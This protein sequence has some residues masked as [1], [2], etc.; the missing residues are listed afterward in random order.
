VRNA[1][2]RCRRQFNALGCCPNVFF[3][4]KGKHRVSASRCEIAKALPR[5]V[6]QKR[7]RTKMA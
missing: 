3:D 2:G 4:R 6:G 1:M 7:P 5:V